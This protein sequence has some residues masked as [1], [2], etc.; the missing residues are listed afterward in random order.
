M[1]E[2]YIQLLQAGVYGIPLAFVFIFFKMW[3]SGVDKR[4]ERAQEEH[5]DDM[6]EIKE[7]FAGLNCVEMS[8][9]IAATSAQLKTFMEF[10]E[11]LTA[12]QDHSID[13]LFKYKDK[14]VNE[15]AE[16]KARVN[17][18]DAD[19]ETTAFKRKNLNVDCLLIEDDKMTREMMTECLKDK[20]GFRVTAAT[21]IPEG[22]SV[23]DSQVFDCAIVDYHCEGITADFFI[24]ECI[25]RNKLTKPHNGSKTVKAL[26]Y[27]GKTGVQAPMG[28]HSLEKPLN[29]SEVR[30]VMECVLSD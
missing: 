25:K 6:N 19:S 5:D 8:S 13:T 7:S 23:L 15:L 21:T 20:L 1:N 29:W 11:R 18:E 17:C 10:T 14:F 28:I 24:K 12:K 3:S 27:T 22:L 9:V 4:I 30:K 16:V 26:L 2:I